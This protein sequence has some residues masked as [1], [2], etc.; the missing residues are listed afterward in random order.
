MVSAFLSIQEIFGYPMKIFF[1]V[2]S[3]RSLEVL[4]FKYMSFIHFKLICVWCEGTSSI[5]PTLT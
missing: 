5:F 3:S 1:H 2:P 4:A